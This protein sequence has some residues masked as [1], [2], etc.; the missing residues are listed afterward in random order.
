MISLVNTN[1]NATE[2]AWKDDFIDK[3][4]EPESP[5]DQDDDD[6]SNHQGSELKILALG[7]SFVGCFS[8][9]IQKKRKS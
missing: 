3:F 1:P 5:L 7:T 9:E 2:A 8:L 4:Y 6:N